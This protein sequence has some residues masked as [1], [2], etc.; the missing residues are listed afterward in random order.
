[1]KIKLLLVLGIIFLTQFTSGQHPRNHPLVAENGECLKCHGQ[2][3]YTVHSTDGKKQMKR[4]MSQ[5]CMIA[6]PEY[7]KAIHGSLKCIDC[8]SEGYQNTPHPAD[9]QFESIYTCTDCHEGSRKFKKFHLDSIVTGYEK[10]VH[11]KT[12]AKTFS[13]WKCHNPHTYINAFSDQSD[14]KSAITVSNATCLDCHNNPVKYKLLTNKPVDNIIK[15]HAWLKHPE[16][17]LKNIRCVDCH[18]KLT[19]GT[20]TPHEILPAKDAVRKCTACHSQNSILS[21]SLLKSDQKR[22]LLGFSNSKSLEYAFI[23]GANRNIWLNI[24][25]ASLFALLLVGLFIHLIFTI[26]YRKLHKNG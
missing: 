17:H 9:L 12:M 13:C 11:A 10:S 4:P 23:M 16:L 20:F 19:S 21:N 24:I 5:A 18:A 6:I 26:R 3:V 7:Q 2:Y 14:L 8:H 22:N 15:E 25:S 1:M